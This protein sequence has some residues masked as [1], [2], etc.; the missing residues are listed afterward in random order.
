MRVAYLCA[1]AQAPPLRA[2]VVP[3]VQPKLQLKGKVPL[4][5][6]VQK[7]DHMQTVKAEVD[8]GQQKRSFKT[9]CKKVS[10]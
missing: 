8:S 2:I 10:L 4:H 9:E 1:I 5:M 3:L 7:S 6:K